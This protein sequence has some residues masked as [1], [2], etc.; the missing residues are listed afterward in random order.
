MVSVFGIILP[1]VDQFR[2][3]PKKLNEHLEHFPETISSY[4]S[5]RDEPNTESVNPQR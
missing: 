3:L 1:I 2:P 4:L 5:Y